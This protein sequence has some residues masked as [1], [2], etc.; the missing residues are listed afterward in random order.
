MRETGEDNYPPM[1]WRPAVLVNDLDLRA[2]VDERLHHICVAHLA[3]PE[4]R[5]VHEQ[6][7]TVDVTAVLQQQTN[8]AG[9]TGESSRVQT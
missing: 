8:G 3:R 7:L 5:R 1:K 2:A 6:I 4:E 9:V